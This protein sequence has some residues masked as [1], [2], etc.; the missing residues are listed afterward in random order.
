M[1]SASFNTTNARTHLTFFIGDGTASTGQTASL[2]LKGVQFAAATGMGTIGDTGLALTVADFLGQTSAATLVTSIDTGI[3]EV[4]KIRNDVGA[5]QNRMERSLDNL[6]LAAENTTNA[7]S[8]IRDADFAQEA[9]ALT[10][11]QLL[12]QAGTSMLSQA[13]VMP[14]TA[15]LLLI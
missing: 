5:L 1:Q 8:T 7:I 2:S 4:A 11:A 9:T 15:L 12:V 3:D 6:V 13:N 10:R 14:Q